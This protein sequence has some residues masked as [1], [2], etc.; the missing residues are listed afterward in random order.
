MAPTR[1][2]V[3]V[4]A[5]ARPGS[6]RLARRPSSL[7]TASRGAIFRSSSRN[8]TPAPCEPVQIRIVLLAAAVLSLSACEINRTPEELLQQR[9]PAEVDR[10]EAADEVRVRVGAFRQAIQRGDRSAAAAA[11]QPSGLA[12]VIGLDAHGRLPRYGPLGLLAAIEELPVP[13]GAV[14]RTPDLR[15]ETSGREGVGWFATHVEL[16]PLRGG[17]PAA[18]RMTGVMARDRGEWRLT[19]VHFSRAEDDAAREEATTPEPATAEARAED[20]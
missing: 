17:E 9:D 16:L 14:A 15:V 7:D 6:L 20:G 11:L 13:E 10:Q 18:F 12:H 8:R 1:T 5:S 19:Q 4:P 2:R 3:K